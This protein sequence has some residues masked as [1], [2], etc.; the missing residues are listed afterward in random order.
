MEEDYFYVTLPSNSSMNQYPKNTVT[1]FTT[2]LNKSINL[3]GDWEVGLAEIVYPQ[4][5]YTVRQLDLLSWWVAKATLPTNRRDPDGYLIVNDED[6][7]QYRLPPGAYK[8]IE[9]LTNAIH[10]TMKGRTGSNGNVQFSVEPVSMRAVFTVAPGYVLWINSALSNLLGFG[11]KQTE[12]ELGPG[13]YKGYDIVD[14]SQEQHS[15]YVYCNI[16]KPQHVGDTAAPLLRVVPLIRKAHNPEPFHKVF[17]HIYFLPL[18]NQNF[19]T[20][21]IDIRDDIGR[22]VAFERG[23]VVITLVF[24]KR[25]T[26]SFFY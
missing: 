3:E 12:T 21:E 14:F 17:D 25:F 10:E 23:R 26:S 13:T 18:V 1:H 19:D 16:I 15:M 22:P 11:K 2:R 4:S 24:K 20:I 9:E 8:K 5:W 7:D 6:G